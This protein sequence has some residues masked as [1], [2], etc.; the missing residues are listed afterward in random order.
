MS[1][2]NLTMDEGVRK[3]SQFLFMDVV[4]VY[5]YF[6]FFVVNFESCCELKL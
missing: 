6:F 5:I 2:N 4:C 3:Y 1:L